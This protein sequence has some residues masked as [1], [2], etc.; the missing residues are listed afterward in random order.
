MY[1]GSTKST[2]VRVLNIVLGGDVRQE[3]LLKELQK[4]R[5]KYKGELSDVGGRW[6]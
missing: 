2:E 5:L 3:K 6:G 4:L 1:S